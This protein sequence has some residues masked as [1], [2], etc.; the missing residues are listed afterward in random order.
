MELKKENGQLTGMFS[1]KELEWMADVEVPTI[2]MARLLSEINDEATL[3]KTFR[4]LVESCLLVRAKKQKHDWLLLAGSLISENLP[5][6]AVLRILEILD[7]NGML[8][9]VGGRSSRSVYKKLV[10]F[11]YIP[12]EIRAGILAVWRSI[13]R[14]EVVN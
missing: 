10:R 8:R 5:D 12:D 6:V 14:E 1:V 13:S 4:F 11:P 7:H 3:G 2:A 9:F